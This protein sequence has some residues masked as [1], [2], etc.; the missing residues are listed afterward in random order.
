MSV[1]D[2]AEEPEADDLLDLAGAIS[3][4]ATQGT[5]IPTGFGP[6][7]KHLRGGGLVP[8]RILAI[9]GPPGAGK[10]TLATMI[11]NSMSPRMRAIGLF[12]DEGRDAA[13]LKLGQQLGYK[14]EDL[15]L[16]APGLVPFIRE[17]MENTYMLPDPDSPASCGTRAI[18]LLAETGDGTRLLVL[19]SAQTIPWERDQKEAPEDRMAITRLMYGVRRETKSRGWLSIV[20]AQANYESFKFKK[21]SANLN[22]LAAFAGS[23]AVIYA[24]DVALVFGI[25]NDDDV[26]K[27]WISKNRLGKKGSFVVK[28]DRERATLMEVDA[29]ELESQEEREHEQASTEKVKRAES[30]ILS[31]LA[32]IPGQTSTQLAET[33]HTRKQHVVQALSSLREAGKIVAT[34]KGRG[35]FVYDLA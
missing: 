34:A 32:K 8:G 27:V 35:S 23:R 15:E 5:P 30:N 18:E 2:W 29:V 14:R 31:Q 4:F 25:P 22:P 9:G 11:L 3:R 28:L 10:T 7:D 13:A 26:C 24:S 12:A 33:C 17:R 20:T 6:L 19:D 1:E 21:E 16:G